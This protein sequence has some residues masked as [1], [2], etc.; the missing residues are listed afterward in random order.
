M[1]VWYLPEAA[2][3]RNKLEPID[4]VALDHAVEK[5][6]RSG[7][8]LPFPHQSNVTGGIGCE[9]CVRVVGEVGSEPF[10]DRSVLKVRLVRRR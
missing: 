9:S 8:R 3:E 2:M 10:T 1:E 6:E 4:R 7:A 5:L